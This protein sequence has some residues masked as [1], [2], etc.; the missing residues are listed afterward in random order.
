M[1]S[2]F[3]TMILVAGP[4]IAFCV[5]VYHNI[6]HADKN[7]KDGNVKANGFNWYP[8]LVVGSILT[9]VVK[10]C[11]FLPSALICNIKLSLRC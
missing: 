3:L 6:V 10:I 7:V 5:K 1:A 9:I 8:V 4:A 2:L 11:S